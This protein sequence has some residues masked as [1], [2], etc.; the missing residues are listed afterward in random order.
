[1]TYNP[2]SHDAM[3]GRSY[4]ATPGNTKERRRYELVIVFA[5]VHVRS[6]TFNLPAGPHFRSAH[7]SSLR[8]DLVL[9]SPKGRYLEQG[10]TDLLI[11]DNS[12]TQPIDVN[13]QS[14]RYEYHTLT[15]DSQLFRILCSPV[16]QSINKPSESIRVNF[17]PSA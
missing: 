5:A 9:R 10:P 15:I 6:C 2:L 16:L 4:V 11:E 1:M 14:R 12:N 13:T 7:T 3:Q 8:C 17:E